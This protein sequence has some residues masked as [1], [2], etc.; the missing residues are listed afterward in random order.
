ME[1][2]FNAPTCSVCNKDATISIYLAVNVLFK[3][4]TDACFY[5]HTSFTILLKRKANTYVLIAHQ[6]AL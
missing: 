3:Y 5:R 2:K 4:I 6:Q 1:Q